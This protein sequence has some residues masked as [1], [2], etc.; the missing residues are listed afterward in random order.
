MEHLRAFV[1]GEGQL[2]EALG[3]AYIVIASAVTTCLGAKD[4]NLSN[5]IASAALILASRIFRHG[6]E[7]EVAPVAYAEPF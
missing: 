3:K 2:S 5:V 1:P 4:G 6:A 7:L